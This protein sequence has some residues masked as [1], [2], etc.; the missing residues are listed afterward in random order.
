M[1][2]ITSSKMIWSRRRNR[3]NKTEVFHRIVGSRK[4]VG[5]WRKALRKKRKGAGKWRIEV[6]RMRKGFVH[7]GKRFYRALRLKCRQR[8]GLY[9]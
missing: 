7:G 1:S 6:S 3:Y 8:N 2:K 4:G 9:T 5:N